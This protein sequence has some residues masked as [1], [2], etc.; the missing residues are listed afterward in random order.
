FSK[1]DWLGKDRGRDISPYFRWVPIVSFLQVGFDIPMATS[2]SQGYG[3][4]FVASE[5]IDAWI[6]TTQPEG[7]SMMDTE[8]LKQKFENF[9]GSPI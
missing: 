6:S 8:A 2:V 5:Y 1:P 4:N 7:W 3:H 9:V